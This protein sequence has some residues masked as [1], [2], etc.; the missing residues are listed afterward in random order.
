MNQFAIG[1]TVFGGFILLVNLLTRQIRERLYL[2][3]ALLAVLFGVA[4]GPVG[5]HL[6]ALQDS[7]QTRQFLGHAA[8]ITVGLAVMDVALT[9]PPGYFTRTWRAIALMLGPG[10]LMMWGFSAGTVYLAA[11]LSMLQ[12]AGIGAVL[13]PTDPVLATATVEGEAAEGVPK[14]LRHFLLA[15]SGS[16]DGL[17][18]PLVMLPLLLIAGPSAEAAIGTWTLK[19]LL[20]G[21]VATVALGGVIG[22]AVAKLVHW[23][24]DGGEKVEAS[25][26]T[27]TVALS[28]LVSGIVDL[29]HGAGIL[30]VFVAGLVFDRVYVEADQ[31]HAERV[32]QSFRRFLELPVFIL[33]G[34]AL[35]WREW[36]ELGWPCIA[37]GVGIL[38]FRRMPVVL[39][40][41]R[42][43]PPIRGSAET[44]FYG[45][46]GPIGIAPLGFAILLWERT[47]MEIVWTLC[48]FIIALSIFA[49]GVTATLLVRKLSK[50]G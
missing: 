43:L 41:R 3:E 26:L 31:V 27:M 23:A 35:P 36:I 45:W 29:Y 6:L 14:R 8:R 17:A 12:A 32:Q 1:L 28:L 4:I 5:I 42:W 25:L 47:Q 22:Y 2:S 9:L 44:W 46:F 21:L 16:N 15:E 7:D 13:T 10:M 18:F 38:L 39:L 30:A 11:P 20:L 33:F 49:H 19:T 37:S 24:T 50:R 34:L 48:S 40:L